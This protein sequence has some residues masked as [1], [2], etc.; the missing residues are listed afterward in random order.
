MLLIILFGTYTLTNS[1]YLDK[2]ILTKENHDLDEYNNI[3]I[4]M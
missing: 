4:N 1:L 3:I 2:K